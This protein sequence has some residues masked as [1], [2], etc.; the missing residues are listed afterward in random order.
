M[1][2]VSGGLEVNH[3][4]IIYAEHWFLSPPFDYEFVINLVPRNFLS[5]I[6]PDRGFTNLLP[7]QYFLIRLIICAL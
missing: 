2:F 6:I 4:F 1:N 5:I 7:K 3:G